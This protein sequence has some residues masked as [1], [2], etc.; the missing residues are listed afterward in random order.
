MCEVNS[1]IIMSTFVIYLIYSL[2]V[3][4]VLINYKLI[5]PTCIV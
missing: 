3:L 2:N 4:N 1:V 5:H